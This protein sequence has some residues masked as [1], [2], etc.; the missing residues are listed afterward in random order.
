MTIR[1][2]LDELETDIQWIA[3]VSPMDVAIALLAQEDISA[4]LVSSDKRSMAGILTSS[5]IVRYLE[6]HQK[7]PGHLRVRSVMTHPVISCDARQ[8]VQRLE[9]LM[10]KHHVRHIPVTKDGEPVA[11]ISILDVTRYRLLTAEQEAA[12][13]RDYV[14]GASWRVRPRPHRQ[15]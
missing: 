13:L 9:W 4:L 15:N 3:P 1:R 12:E 2:L 8:S 11:V 10:S 14:A 6:A 5:D 7:L